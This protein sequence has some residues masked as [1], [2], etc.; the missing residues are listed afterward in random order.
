MR[1]RTD[2]WLNAT[3]ILK[4]A[5]VPKAKRT[6]IL[7]ALEREVPAN[8]HEKVQGGY[9][10]YQ[11][12]WI[13]FERGVELCREWGVD[14]ALRCLLDLGDERGTAGG[15]DGTR[16]REPTPTKEEVMA[17]QRKRIYRGLDQPRTASP[18]NS[19]PDASQ[20]SSVH[21][22]QGQTYFQSISHTAASAV[23]AMNQA[24]FDNPMARD[25][26]QQS[27]SA[28]QRS[29]TS[30]Q[31]PHSQQLYLQQDTAE[32]SR[33]PTPSRLSSQSQGQSQSMLPPTET[34]GHF[35]SV[36]DSAV[37]H[38]RGSEPPPRKRMRASPFHEDGGASADLVAH[39]ARAPP[40]V[41]LEDGTDA[42]S[43]LAVSSTAHAR[44]TSTNMP[45][46]PP[47]TNKSFS[48][49]SQFDGA[50][51]S[52]PSQRTPATMTAS[53]AAQEQGRPA[54]PL[55][56]CIKGLPPLQAATTS[57]RY[58]TQ[59]LVMTLFLDKKV[60]DFTDHPAILTLDAID[61]E[62][63]LDEHLNTALHWAAMLARMPLIYALVKKGVSIFRL[64]AA[65]ETALQKAVG[66]R[67]NFDYRSFGK[68]LGVLAPTIEVA[69]AAG[70]NVL[71]HICMLAATGG[72]GHVAA[73]HYLESLLDFIVKQGGR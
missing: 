20:G 72:G 24:R 3:Q 9:G 36:N 18:V 14:G 21:G 45:P 32:A 70:R 51:A 6:K 25:Y 46:P 37:A 44:N 7:Q 23:N 30:Q 42:D 5:G 56:P 15:G 33:A 8:K 58:Q 73:R 69:D 1:R 12:T 19:A 28:S 34:S 26:G 61:L 55:P 41:V 35:R 65:G 64:N 48:R 27:Q 54:L 2:S 38:E 31:Q 49:V 29:S 22:S 16:R 62:I 63:P 53:S 71:H 40:R 47:V 17:L 59:K 10:K 57:D 52:P 4:V 11:G 13:E 39:P 68:L 67:N 50:P 43:R 60:R 66:T